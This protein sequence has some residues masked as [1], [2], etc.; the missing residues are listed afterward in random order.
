M[1]LTKKVLSLILA[2]ALLL[3]TV[4]IAAQ[5]EGLTAQAG[6]V[7]TFV[8]TSDKT[9]D[10]VTNVKIGETVKV[11]VY[12]S[13]NYYTGS[14]GG[15]FFLWTSGIFNDLGEN[16]TVSNFAASFTNTYKNPAA[17]GSY[18][19]THGSA[20]YVG[21]QVVRINNSGVT[22]AQVVD[23]EL[24]YE[25]ELTVKDDENL[26][27]KT[28]TFEVPAGSVMSPSL[29]GRKALIYQG[30]SGTTDSITDVA[31]YAET[32]DLTAAKLTMNI[33][34]KDYGTN[35]CDYSKL[36]S[37]EDACDAVEY[38]ASYYPADEYA[39]WET[40]LAAAN[41][42]IDDM[43]TNGKA[44]YSEEEQAKIDKAASDLQ[45]AY[46]ALV[47]GFVDTTPIS[48]ALAAYG[49]APLAEEYYA[50]SAWSAHQSAVKSANSAINSYSQLPDSAENREAV[51]DVADAVKTAYDNLV[52]QYVDLT[53][54]KAA[55]DACDTP[56]YAEDYY[57]ATAWSNWENALAEANKGVTDYAEAADT[58]AN[59]EAV[60]TL[61]NALTD[62]YAALDPSVLDLTPLTDAI[63]AYSTPEYTA[64]YYDAKAW[65]DWEDA[66]AAAN[67]GVEDYTGAANTAA[68]QQAI[69]DLANALTNAYVALVPV[70]V[71][72]QPITD[73][74]GAYGAVDYSEEHYDAEEYAAWETALAAADDADFSTAADT[75]ENRAAVQKIADDLKVAYEA[76]DVRFVDTTPITDT[77]AACVPEYAEEYYDQAAWAEFQVQVSSGATIAEDY[78]TQPDTE[79]NR[80]LV[81]EYVTNITKA[82]NALVPAFVSYE[83]VEQAIADYSEA[84]NPEVYYTPDSWDN[85]EAALAAAEEAN[86]NRPDPLPAATEANQ[87]A[88]DKYATDLE[89]AYN[90]LTP[91]GGCS[92]ISVTPMQADYVMGDVINLKVL[93]EGTGFAKIQF[94][95]V[96]GTTSTYH[97]THSAVKEIYEEDGNEV[98]VIAQKVP[99]NNNVT[100]YAKAK[101]G[102]NWDNGVV[103]FEFV[104]TKEDASVKSVEILLNG[105]AVT[106]FLN[107]D[108]V[109]VRI[110]TGPA[111]RRMRI[112][113]PVSGTTSTY[114]APVQV[115]TDGTKVW[116]FTRKYG[117]VKSYDFDIHTA[118]SNN[119]LVD[120][121][122]DLEFTVTKY[123]A[124]Q[125]P[126]TGDVKDAVLAASVAKAR[127]LKGS[128]QTFTIATDKD[129][130]AVRIKNSNGDVIYRA[131]E[132]VSDD[133]VAKTWVISNTYNA[134]GTYNYTVEALYGD[135]WLADTDGVLTFKVLY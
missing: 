38:P 112:V 20:D 9:V 135:T 52:P 117:T 108:T 60:A 42:I 105:E 34:S 111:T 45:A 99:S 125:V 51:Q 25:F 53:N 68:N 37:T 104:P 31:K 5:A 35:Y 22:K 40:A 16:Y 101:M 54:L 56:V 8:I 74:I 94:I 76:L 70:F 69:A 7:Q 106:E 13:T 75:E 90:A 11:Q 107:T 91:A 87:A 132:A 71:S 115:N 1:K 39:A 131:T 82:Y 46:N 14:A 12:M 50:T 33:V 21:F 118:N 98:W 83:K 66:L 55:I 18:P 122:A 65:S 44:V 103:S 2:A 73:A 61:T 3:G 59:Q 133:G 92:I 121:G 29:T 80:A 78:K 110:V 84:P 85:Y 49:T 79:E 48:D 114:S 124:P 119:R 86:T 77:I 43:N 100:R 89:N 17:T 15:D 4:V 127:I 134:L 120:S 63:T 109:T 47:A 26:I 57:D 24:V 102:R 96:N 28:A 67:K 93:C 10:G 58:A 32:V 6:S 129:A 126:S 81:Q 27:G 123:V 128:V 36:I 62:A 30:V 113:N 88:V 130:K 23:N 116:E 41:A 72:T 19:S 64:E 97:R 95:T